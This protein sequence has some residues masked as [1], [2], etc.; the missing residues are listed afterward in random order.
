MR[1]REK[2]VDASRV[3]HGG[4]DKGRENNNRVNKN[5]INRSR[6]LAAGILLAMALTAAGC[7]GKTEVAGT[8]NTGAGEEKTLKIGVCA[9]PYGDMFTKAVTPYLKEK[10]YETKIVEFTDYVQPDMA[11]AEGEID[12]NL[13][14]HQAYLDQFAK[15]NQVE[16]TSVINVP[17]LG[18]GIFSET[19][20]TLS[21]LQKGDRVALPTDAVNLARALRFLR[22]CGVIS[23]SDEIDETKA[24]TADITE[25]PNQLEFVTMDAAQISR[26]LDSVAIGVIPGNYAVAAG[27]DYQKALAVERLKE[28]MKNVIA[29]RTDDRDG[30]GSIGSLLKEAVESDTFYRAITEDAFYD[31]FDR[32]EWWEDQ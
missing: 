15:D 7:A 4:V 18:M 27:M 19:H 1:M 26:S 25:N 31:G 32:P 10:G 21:E 28:E 24:G 8:K 12:A 30:E 3:I 22:D 9:G 29:V 5:R 14:Q 23:I 17:T 2:R 6:L 16:I 13:M 20:D 11:L